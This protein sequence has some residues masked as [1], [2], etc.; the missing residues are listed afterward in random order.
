VPVACRHGRGWA[1]AV[2]PPEF[3]V[4]LIG[5]LA[6]LVREGR[7]GWRAL[8]VEMGRPTLEV[9]YEDFVTADGYAPTLRAIVEKLDLGIDL[10]RL[11]IAQTRT[12]RQADS[13]N[14][15]WVARYCAEQR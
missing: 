12:R 5:N 11:R 14:D 9:V 7:D 3:D 8:A 6:R 10:D 13:L 15:S 4:T 1:D 2:A